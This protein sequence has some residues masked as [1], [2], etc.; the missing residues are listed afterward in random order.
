MLQD[1]RILLGVTG[2]IAAYKAVQLASDLRKLGAQLRVVMT[3]NATKLVT[4][5]TFET[6]T[7]NRVSVDTFDRGFEW[8]VG[9]IGLAQWAELALVA[10]ATANA[11]AKLAGGLADDLLSTS[12]LAVRC[13]VLLCPA[14]NTAMYEHPATQHNLALL[15]SRGV[16]FVQPES[17]QLACGDEGPGRLAGLPTIIDAAVAALTPKTLAGKRVLVT[18]GPTC[19]DIDPVR[20]ISNRSTGKMGYEIARAAHHLGAEV[21]LVSGPVSLIPPPGVRVV[22]VRSA[23]EMR[24]EVLALAPTQDIIVKS[25]AVADFR[26]Q[27]TSTQKL[28]KSQTAPTLALEQNP[29]ILAE[30]CAAK[31]TGQKVVGFAMETQALAEN[32]R[33]KLVQKNVDMLVANDLTTPGAGFGGDTNQVLLLTPQQTLPLPLM[34][35]YQLGLE[36][37]ARLNSL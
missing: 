10:P 6:I 24:R 23:M 25:A 33:Q 21:T 8:Q 14:M 28:K 37:F 12:L 34:S 22:A 5:L 20:F 36:I 11:L 3:N 19:E 18:A 9:H 2:G 32:A 7:G 13:P 29:D 26:A 1:K 15:A 31:P 16:L 17:G 30:L 35:K 27:T 4:P